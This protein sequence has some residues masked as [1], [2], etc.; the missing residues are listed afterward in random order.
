MPVQGRAFLALALLAAPVQ[1]PVQASAQPQLPVLDHIVVHKAART[2][3]L[4]VGA[5]VV[6]VFR[7]IQLG[8]P[9]GA[10]RFQGDRRTPEGHYRID[11]GNGD[12]AYRLS[13]HISY[14]APA[15]VARARA[16]GRSPGGAV[17]IH[18]QP[19]DR[20]RTGSGSGRIAGDWTDGCIA[21]AD[22]EIEAL[23]R[24]TP[25]GTPIDIYP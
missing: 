23:W 6:H 25:D 18:G 14:P 1:A 5:R 3:E 7:G 8:N 22:D 9:V 10:K 16:A 11:Y 24:A 20:P 17:F 12:S 2:M 4:Y 19:D 21:L 15:D 13:L